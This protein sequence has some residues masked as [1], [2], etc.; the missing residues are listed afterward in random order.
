M[1]TNIVLALSSLLILGF[2]FSFGMYKRYVLSKLLNKRVNLRKY[3]LYILGTIFLYLTFLDIKDEGTETT[4]KKLPIYLLLDVSR[5]M[6]VEDVLP[7]R[8]KLAKKIMSELILGIDRD[9]AIVVFASEAYSFLPET[10]DRELALT[11]LD[12]LNEEYIVSGSTDIS[13]ALELAN[14]DKLEKILVVFS[15]GEDRFRR[16]K[17]HSSRNCFYVALGTKHGGPIPTAEGFLKDSNG[18]NII[19]K[20]DI[21]YL[22]S[23]GRVY[24]TQGLSRDISNLKEDIEKISKDS[25]GEFK[26]YKRYYQIFLALAIIFL[27]LGYFDISIFIFIFMLSCTDSRVLDADKLYLDGKFKDALEIYQSLNLEREINSCKVKLGDIKDTVTYFK[28]KAIE[29]GNID[30]KFML[31]YVMNMLDEKENRQEDRQKNEN[32][33]ENKESKKSKESEKSK[34]DSSKHQNK[35]ES[36]KKSQKD[37][38]KNRENIEKD[39]KQKDGKENISQNQ[40]KNEKGKDNQNGFED[41]KESKEDSKE[42]DNDSISSKDGNS[43]EK[44]DE[45]RDKKDNETLENKED[46]SG[47]EMNDSEDDNRNNKLNNENKQFE[48]IEKR[49]NNLDKSSN[50]KVKYDKVT[51]EMIDIIEKAIKRDISNYAKSNRPKKLGGNEGW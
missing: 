5:S 50:K 20:V 2:L 40:E 22:S 45:S 26:R 25:E 41:K 8:L 34:G 37:S 21:S 18:K 23:L 48:N 47:N 3:I 24:S 42:E 39:N 28:S 46:K 1:D 49:E 35:D 51:E 36:E 15:D 32:S 11:F 9:V 7:N 10:S 27:M 16:A 4:K 33:R 31:E 38:E 14:M 6:L 13:K 43:K 44:V 29:G 17:K 19:S 12:S 30:D